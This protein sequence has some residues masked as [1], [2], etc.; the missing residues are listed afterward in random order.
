VRAHRR[1]PRG[2]GPSPGS[3]GDGRKPFATAVLGGTFDHLHAGHRSLLATAFR[4]A[5]EV[6]IGITTDEFLRVHPK[7]FPERIEPYRVRRRRLARFLRGAYGRRRWWLAALD[8]PWGRSVEPGISLLVVSHATRA[9]VPAIQAERRRR[10]L[11]PIAV[12]VAPT[13]VAEDGQPIA[14]SRIRAGEI[15]PEGRPTSSTT[16]SRPRRQ[17]IRPG[18]RSGSRGQSS[19]HPPGGGARSPPEGWLRFTK[20]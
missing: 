2:S 7:R 15:D 14:S 4:W 18:A 5:S 13:A 9:A 1:R 8:D 19:I 11:P 6:G 17:A 10:G 16:R 20:G 3:G 12:R